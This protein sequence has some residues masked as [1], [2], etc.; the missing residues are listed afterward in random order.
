MYTKEL[1]C[2]CGAQATFDNSPDGWYARCPYCDN[3]ASVICNRENAQ[4]AL[5]KELNRSYEQIDLDLYIDNVMNRHFPNI[6]H[7]PHVVL[8]NK[9][10]SVSFEIGCET[11]YSSRVLDDCLCAYEDLY[12]DITHAWADCKHCGSYAVKRVE[13][14]YDDNY[15]RL[16]Q[17]RCPDCTF[18]SPPATDMWDLDDFMHSEEEPLRPSN[19]GVLEMSILAAHVAMRLRSKYKH[20]W[21][22]PHILPRWK[23]LQHARASESTCTSSNLDVVLERF[24]EDYRLA[25]GRLLPCPHCCTQ[26]EEYAVPHIYGMPGSYYV[27]CIC[28]VRAS[29]QTTL[30]DAVTC[31]HT[32]WHINSDAMQTVD[33]ACSPSSPINVTLP[34]KGYQ[35]VE[36]GQTFVFSGLYGGYLRVTD[37]APLDRACPCGGYFEW[38]YSH[39]R[40]RFLKCSTCGAHSDIES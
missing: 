24:L 6:K 36:H 27:Q 22:Q 13:V 12:E 18:V 8:K 26:G 9:E 34:E 28:G 17:A 16:V 33:M 10:W 32:C 30:S 25:R 7:R 2:V 3:E 38:D 5:E 19:A 20:R 1:R 23:Y 4:A 29:G 11:I 21:A 14:V 40:G 15:T 31:W 35:L 37:S 39:L